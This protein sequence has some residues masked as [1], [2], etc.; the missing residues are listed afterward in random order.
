MNRELAALPSTDTWV[1]GLVALGWLL[2][3]TVTYDIPNLHE[4][5]NRYRDSKHF[6]NRKGPHC[7][8]IDRW[9]SRRDSQQA[10]RQEQ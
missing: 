9:R 7:S 10:R 6:D 5:C 4:T 1:L 3:A 8:S 2:G